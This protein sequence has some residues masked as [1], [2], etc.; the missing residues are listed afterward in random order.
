M[1]NNHMYIKTIGCKYNR[2]SFHLAPAELCSDFIK[3]LC[4][5]SFIIGSV[6]GFLSHCIAVKHFYN[7]IQHL[8]QL[9]YNT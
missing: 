9:C 2:I 7:K 6:T 8:V 1:F 5:F 4:S 3:I